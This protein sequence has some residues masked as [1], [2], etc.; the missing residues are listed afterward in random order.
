MTTILLIDDDRIMRSS[1]TRV[2]AREGYSIICAEDG[3]QGLQEIDSNPGIDLILVDQLMPGMSGM[4]L[5]AHARSMRPELP[6]VVIP[7]FATEE[8][9][10]ETKQKGALDCLVKPFTPEQLRSAVKRALN[11]KV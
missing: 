4:D 5:L 10:R 6:V 9:I 11:A 1:C 2:L 3:I 8:C 7:G